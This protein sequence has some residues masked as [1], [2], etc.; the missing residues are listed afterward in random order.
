MTNYWQFE[1]ETSDS[2][3][4][5]LLIALLSNAGFEGFEEEEKMIKAFVGEKNFD[6]ICFDEAIEKMGNIIYVRS[7][8]ENIN[9]NQQWE[10][11]FEPV[12][13]EQFV[14]IRAH[15]H[16]PIT[17][18]KHEIVITPKMSF[19]TGHHATTFMVLQLMQQLEFANKTV[20]DFGTGTGVLAI[21]A[22]KLGASHINAIDNDEWS[23]NNTIENIEQ[24][25]CNKIEVNLA[26]AIPIHK[27]YDVI[28]ANIN[29]NIILKNLGEIAAASLPGTEI[30]LSGFLSTDEQVI[31]DGLTKNGLAFYSSLKKGEW[32]A[33]YCGK[34]L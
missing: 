14:A 25:N 3:Q 30:L 6:E 13:V 12:V 27:K 11:S 29:L 2:N 20:L 16:Q 19:G 7:S 8:I 26:D 31:K 34:G 18:V 32:L 21:L 23:I 1:F 9:W 10:E 5:E 28:I 15:F 33:I 22:E 24:N 17:S 4:A